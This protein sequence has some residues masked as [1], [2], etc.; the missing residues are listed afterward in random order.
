M[1]HLQ[2]SYQYTCTKCNIHVPI[3]T[4]IFWKV[5]MVFNNLYPVIVSKQKISGTFFNKIIFSFLQFELYKNT[6]CSLDFFSQILNHATVLK[7]IKKF[8]KKNTLNMYRP[9]TNQQFSLI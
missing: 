4:M 6:L 1:F 8:S 5:A 7:N 9:K 3:G 2:E